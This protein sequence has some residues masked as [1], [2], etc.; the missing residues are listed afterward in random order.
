MDTYLGEMAHIYRFVDT[1][2]IK[3]QLKSRVK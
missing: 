2:F 3:R 1:S